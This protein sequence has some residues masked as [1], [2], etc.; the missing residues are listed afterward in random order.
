M[1]RVAMAALC[2]ALLGTAT[3][4]RAY[5]SKDIGEAAR[6]APGAPD[7]TAPTQAPEG[8]YTP[9]EPSG[10]PT[11][12]EWARN[13]VAVLVT[14][15]VVDAARGY[16]LAGALVVL[17]RPGGKPHEIARTDTTGGVHARFSL[18]DPPPTLKGAGGAVASNVLV[19]VERP[20]YLPYEG[21]FSPASLPKKGV[22]AWIDLGDLRMRAVPIEPVK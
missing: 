13:E 7:A 1:K 17:M 14:A 16:P 18:H 10:S 15:R 2:A 20:D 22:Y 8:G 11:Q 3:A 9:G 21:S 5:E 12:D 19:R 4:A 6:Q